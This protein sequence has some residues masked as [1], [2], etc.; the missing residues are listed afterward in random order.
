M[1]ARAPVVVVARWQVRGSV[2]EVLELVAR[3]RAASL[4]EPGCLGY[5]VYRAAAAPDT[6]LL[7]EHYR[8]EAALQAHRQSAHYGSL[9]VDGVL[10]RLA[11]RQVEILQRL[12]AVAPA[13]EPCVQASGHSTRAC[14][15]QV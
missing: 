9:V 14:R 12:G 13:T 4:A 6:L 11:A 1:A 10:P 3:L 5:E 8:D 7:L 15:Q 2:D